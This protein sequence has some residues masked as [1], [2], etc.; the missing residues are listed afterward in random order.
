MLYFK[1]TMKR[2]WNRVLTMWQP[3][4]VLILGLLLIVFLYG[5]RLSSLAPGIHSTELASGRS[6][7]SLQMILDNPVNAPYKLARY[8]VSR[9]TTR[10]DVLRGM[11]AAASLLMILLFYR[12]ACRFFTHLS[13]GLGTLLF[14]TSTLLL[15]NGRLAT[16]GIM[17]LSLFVL[18]TCGYAL[19]F[20]TRN[21][22][23]WLLA[24]LAAALALYVPGMVY[25]ILAGALWQLKSLQRPIGNTKPLVLVGCFLIIMMAAGSIAY[26]IFRDPASWRTFLGLPATLPE[27][28]TM[29]KNMASVPFG[30]FAL[31][32]ENPLYR[33]GKQPILDVFSGGMFVLGCYALIKKH[34]LDRAKLLGGI[35]IV[36]TLWIAVSGNFENILILLP[37]LYLVVTAGLQWMTNEWFKVFPHNPLAR[38]GALVLITLAVFFSCAF[39]A[40]RYFLA[41]PHNKNT[42]AEFQ[43]S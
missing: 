2:L 43:R 3:A 38:G 22:M 11:S 31:A 1:V 21:S 13:A 19:R 4:T 6:S 40:R 18:I 23:V 14:A 36:A 32:P 17:L 42:I 35:F 10:I 33:L 20:N 7:N 34:A 5:Y 9:L 29:L 26:A 37:F 39:Q 16:P 25:F 15:N 30:I 41:W 12:I 28:L 27:P 24:S 8:G